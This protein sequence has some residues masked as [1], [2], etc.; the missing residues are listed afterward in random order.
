M[1]TTVLA[2]LAC[3]VTASASSAQSAT[4]ADS[5]WERG[6]R[7]AARRAYAEEVAQH[8]TN[9]RA[10]FR[11]ASLT[12][13]RPDA[14]ALYRRYVALE[15]R[16]AWGWMAL[17]DHL[18][19]MGD[20]AEAL[21]MYDRA[22]QV[23]PTERDVSI[24]RARILANAG[25]HALAAA[26]LEGWAI[27]HADDGEAWQEAGR[28]WQRSARPRRASA[29]FAK[30]AALGRPGAALQLRRARLAAAPALEPG[31]GHASDSDGNRT[32]RLGVTADLHAGGATRVGFT[33]LHNKVGD[34][35]ATRSIHDGLV[36]VAVR[37]GANS[38]FVV[39]A[40]VARMD[41]TAVGSASFTAAGDMRL[42]WRA[43]SRLSIELR[44]QRFPVGATPQLV[45][46]RV[47]RT[48]G[49]ATLG[50][51]VGPLVARAGARIGAISS[52]VDDNSRFLADGILAL[53]VSAGTELSVQ[54][55][56][57]HYDHATTAGYFA[58]EKV[59]T[60]EGVA[61]A[62]FEAG[63]VSLALD[64]GVGAQRVK[65]FGANVGPWRVALRA[66]GSMEVPLAA[67]A[68]LRFEA[69]AY[70]APFAAEGVATT[71]HWKYLAL[72]VGLRWRLG[73]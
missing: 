37:P 57:V 23:L 1:R 22:A 8:P 60:V 73:R 47:V 58:P 54:Y 19:R 42:R 39:R 51:P 10:I 63:S 32:T 14:L 27:A 36:R 52:I 18:A 46:N 29:A 41:A 17:G 56:R 26:A 53:P 72:N 16:D 33:Y 66:W 28:A 25:R 31:V 70:D 5:V 3:V 62:E 48:E 55:H 69:E 61:S 45:D 13:N 12:A 40:G 30:A 44:G 65:V 49:G 9:S 64:A 20:T 6:D 59:E 35:I 7:E 38:Q 4:R 11:L 68:A 34:G 24:G 67:Q 43:P 50:V 71:D 21:A 2:L 15:P